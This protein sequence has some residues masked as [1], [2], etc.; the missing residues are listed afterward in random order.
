MLTDVAIRKINT[1]PSRREIRDDG[2]PGLYLIVQPT[3]A[4]SFAARY[5]RNGRVLK[6]TIGPYPAVTLA[7]AR[8]QALQIAAAVASGADPQSDR[9]AARAAANVPAERTVAEVAYEFLKR[10]TDEKN[11]PRWAAETRRIVDRNILPVIGD[12]AFSSV[13]KADIHDMLDAIKDRGTPIA[14]NRTLSVVAKLFRWALTRSYVDRDP[15]AGLPKPASEPKRDRVLSDDELARVWHAAEAMPYPF[16]PAVRLLVL[17]GARRDEVGGM[18]WSEVDIA[19][20]VWTLPAERAKNGVE[21]VIPLSDAAVGILESVPR[22]GWRDGFVFTMT[23]RTPISGWSR[24][25]AQLDNASGVAG[26]TL[27]DLRRTFATGLAELGVAL[28]VVEKILNHIS[29]S[30]GGVA[31]VYQRFAFA[32][33]KRDALDKWAARVAVIVKDTANGV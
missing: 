33:E 15:C 17:T 16:G 2:A 1:P 4:K 9:R 20:R 7:D 6:T 12:K 24:A 8:R 28:P 26:W 31:G 30:F 5:S 23:G 10:H 27:H 22:I 32:D 19:A 11:G 18:R 29:G 21:H 3:G 13:G 14:A 25:K